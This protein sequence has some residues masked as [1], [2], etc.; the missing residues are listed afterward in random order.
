MDSQYFTAG[1]LFGVL[2]A[3]GLGMLLA[4]FLGGALLRL[5]VHWVEKATPG[6]WR[7]VGAVALGFGFGF[8][9]QSVLGAVFAVVGPASALLLG[10][11]PGMAWIVV[12]A[13]GG[14]VASVLALALSVLL[15]VPGADGRRMP[16]ARAV[17]ASALATL[18]GTVLYGAV[19][20]ALLLTFGGVPGCRADQVPQPSRV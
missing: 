15:V 1:V 18:M 20:V 14:F 8:V 19:V 2:F 9:V 16:F 4:L 17:A 13:V 3:V 7:C 10:T 6:Y 11:D 12:A 5:S